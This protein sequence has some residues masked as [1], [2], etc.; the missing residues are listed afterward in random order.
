MALRLL[1]LATA[2]S[3]LLAPTRPTQPTKLKGTYRLY[4]V[5]V[6]QGADPGAA[7]PSSQL[8][9]ALKK[10]CKKRVTKK[11]RLRRVIRVVRK[12]LDVRKKLP[13][14]RWTYVVDVE[15]A[16]ALAEQPGRCERLEG[17]SPVA[18]PRG[19]TTKKS[20]VVVGSGPAGLFAALQLASDGCAVTLVE[21][22]E[23]VERRG[24][25]IGRHMAGRQLQAQSNFC[26]GEGGAGAAA[27]S[28][29]PSRR[30][31]APR[32]R[33]GWGASIGA[34]APLPTQP[35]AKAQREER[36][37]EQKTTQARGPTASSRRASAATRA[38]S[39]RSCGPSC[40]TARR[41]R[42]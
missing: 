40:A 37:A 20:A 8:S 25:D 24:R 18:V 33:Q 3:A 21:R 38:T 14:P 16:G 17:A 10:A 9:P 5:V 28:R 19:T 35:D 1:A 2:A 12:S 23:P 22:G 29:V 11:G 42:S 30:N 41:P 13:E 7:A 15:C 39:A 27:A 32:R 36:E 34:G 6:P 31:A 4:D 26:F